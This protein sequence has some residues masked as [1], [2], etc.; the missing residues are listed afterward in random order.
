V[1]NL[2]P[3]AVEASLNKTSKPLKYRDNPKIYYKKLYYLRQT[4]VSTEENVYDRFIELWASA[5]HM[6]VRALDSFMAGRGSR[7]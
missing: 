6:I 2:S 7:N 5:E 3:E 1:D 4:L